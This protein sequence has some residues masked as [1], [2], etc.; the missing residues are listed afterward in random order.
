MSE[1]SNSIK[2]LAEKFPGSTSELARQVRIDRSTLYKIMGGRRL[3]TEAQLQNLLSVLHATPAEY[4]ALTHLYA[5]SQQTGAAA[6]RQ[7]LLQALLSSAF[8]AQRIIREAVSLPESGGTP[9]SAPAFLQGEELRT[10][11]PQRLRQ[12]LLSGDA[13]PLMLSPR[14]N[15]TVGRAMVTAFASGVSAPKP[16]WQLCQFL[17]DG[18]ETALD[19]NIKALTEIT[20][21]LLLPGI[22]YEGRLC[23]APAAVPLPGLPMPVYLLFPDL[24]LFMDEAA[25]SAICIRDPAAVEFVRLQYSRQYLRAPHPLFLQAQYHSAE[26]SMARTQT[27]SSASGPAFWLRDQP[28]LVGCLDRATMLSALLPGAP[29]AAVGTETLLARQR[30]IAA[31]APHCYFTENGVLRFLRTG[32]IDDVP[33]DL[34]EPLPME[35]RLALLRTLRQQCAGSNRILRLLNGSALAATAGIT[36]DIYPGHGVLLGQHDEARKDYR[37]CFLRERAVTDAL[38]SY[39]TELR[40]SELVCSQ[41]YTLEFLDYCLQ[42]GKASAYPEETPVRIS[43]R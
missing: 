29:S 42:N 9:L 43:P 8:R 26:E 37:H 40:T 39:L 10:F 18:S 15:Q 7:Q 22:R 17:E 13:R 32:R 3:P 14:L 16:V 20:P 5:H 12:Y 30:D 36:V 2:R 24:C 25:H 11:L 6:H 34:Y 31:L 21:L 19:E 23:Y 28:P 4:T 41:S 38:F 27:L 35:T 33:P 1:L